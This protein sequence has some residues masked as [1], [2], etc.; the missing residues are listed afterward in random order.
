MLILYKDK[1]VPVKTIRDDV[2]LKCKVIVLDNDDGTLLKLDDYQGKVFD[3]VGGCLTC[4]TEV[5]VNMCCSGR[6]CGCM[7]MPIDPPFCSEECY[8][9]YKYK[10]DKDGENT[11]IPIDSWNHLIDALRY[12]LMGEII[13]PRRARITVLN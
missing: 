10:K 9:N 4:G 5:G 3:D 8:K 12:W 1:Y 2:G 7:G 11:N 13:E 6:E